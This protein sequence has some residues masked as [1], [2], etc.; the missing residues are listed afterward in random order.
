MTKEYYKKQAEKHF[1]MYQKAL[2]A[3]NKERAEYHMK[4]YL[5]YEKASK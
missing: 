2:D 5:T 1:K 3:D 4:E